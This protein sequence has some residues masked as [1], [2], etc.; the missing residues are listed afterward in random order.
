M[1]ENNVLDFWFIEL[2]ENDWFDKNPHL[3]LKI[4]KKLNF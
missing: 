1:N 4:K 3:D 2:N